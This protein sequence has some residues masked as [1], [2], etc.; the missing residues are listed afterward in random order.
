M[1][2]TRWRRKEPWCTPSLLLRTVT[3]CFSCSVWTWQCDKYLSRFLR[4]L[5]ML[6]CSRGSV[7]QASLQPLHTLEC[8]SFPQCWVPLADLIQYGFHIYLDDSLKLR[9]HFLASSL[10]A[11]YSQPVQGNSLR[12]TMAPCTFILGLTTLHFILGLLR[13]YAKPGRNFM[14]SKL[15]PI[16]DWM[17][18]LLD[19]TTCRTRLFEEASYYRTPK[20]TTIH[21][22][23]IK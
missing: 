18:G 9:Y 2:R 10:T 4:E 7:L 23:K 15:N 8:L 5:T 19:A 14:P 13:D 12:D 6:C 20:N 11:P 1:F 3:T 21:K 17:Q 22:N 16:K